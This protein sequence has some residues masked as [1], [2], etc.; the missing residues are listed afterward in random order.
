M[1]L[2][3]TE[4][5]VPTIRNPKKERINLKTYNDI[6]IIRK[7]MKELSHIETE[8]RIISQILEI[9]GIRKKRTLGWT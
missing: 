1:N 2:D 6:P 4:D 8:P 7:Q 3:W 9:R 5:G